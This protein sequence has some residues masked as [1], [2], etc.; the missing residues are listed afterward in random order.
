MK[1]GMS[2]VKRVVNIV[3]TALIFIFVGY[4][5]FTFTKF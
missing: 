3:L 2:I 1:N 5:L 4:L